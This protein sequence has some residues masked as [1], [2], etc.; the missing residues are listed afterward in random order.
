MGRDQTGDC[1]RAQACLMMV[2]MPDHVAAT[3]P[4]QHGRFR[5]SISTDTGMAALETVQQTPRA[6]LLGDIAFGPLGVFVGPRRQLQPAETGLKVVSLLDALQFQHHR[7]RESC[8]C[9]DST[10]DRPS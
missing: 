10:I 3:Y 6:L 1:G 9:T 5:Y 4:R 2:A 8:A 7:K